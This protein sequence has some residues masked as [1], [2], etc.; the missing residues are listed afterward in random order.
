MNILS[1]IPARGGSK[2]VP[3]K[4]V[5]RVAGKPLIAWTIEAAQSSCVSD[6]FFVSTDDTEITQVAREWGAAV[7]PRPSELAGDKTPMVDVIRH[8]FLENEKEAGRQFDYF[9]LLQPTAPMRTGEDIDQALKILQE[10]GAD[11]VVSVYQVEDA[12]PSRMYH[13]V[14]GWLEPF[15]QEPPGSLRQDLSAVYHRNGAVYACKRELLLDRGELWGGRIAPYIMPLS[16]S[17]NID[18]PIDLEWA[19]FL[20]SRDRKDSE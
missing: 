20:L 19:D 14:G 5:R 13:Q 4:N 3:R 8:V 11:S 12:H 18:A 7:K 17:A 15:Y 10:S 1:M 2:G 6:S 9:L 16:R